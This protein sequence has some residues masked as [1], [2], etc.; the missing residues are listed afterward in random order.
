MSNDR[1]T[2]VLTGKLLG[3]CKL[4]LLS[5][6][7]DISYSGTRDYMAPEVRDLPDNGE[8][9]LKTRFSKMIDMFSAGLVIHELLSGKRPSNDTGEKR[10]RAIQ[11]MTWPKLPGDLKNDLGKLL[12]WEARR[13]PT[14][15]FMSARLSEW[16]GM[17]EVRP[18]AYQPASTTCLLMVTPN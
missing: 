8:L 3:T 11:N 16:G 14:A 13:R 18:R 7:I 17:N 4:N 15:S 2:F 1:I 12:S 9:V 10:R 5:V 6:T